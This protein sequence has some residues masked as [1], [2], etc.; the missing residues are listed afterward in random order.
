MRRAVRA[1]DRLNSSMPYATK[2]L[3][4][5]VL[6]GAGDMLC[7]G[8]INRHHQLVTRCGAASSWDSERT[9]RMFWW[10]ALCNGPAGHLWY[11][12][13]DHAVHATGIGGRRGVIIKVI[14]DQAIF[15]PPLT[16]LFFMWQHILS[17]KVLDPGP[18][19]DFANANLWPTLRVN[20]VYWSAVHVITFA[21]VPLPYRVAFVAVKN[22]FWGAY[23]SFT[24][25]EPDHAEAAHERQ[26]RRL[27]RTSTH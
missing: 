26:V 12:W 10:G 8:I 1:Y 6:L 9:A 3:T 18:A 21:F 25:G 5:G 27:A 23:L 15:T 7:Q 19:A 16:Y 22:F 4:C 13:L 11:R 20:V 2:G 24:L 14:A 17:T